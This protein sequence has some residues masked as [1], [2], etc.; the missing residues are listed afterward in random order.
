MDEQQTQFS[1]KT[2][3]RRVLVDYFS[4]HVVFIRKVESITAS[5]LVD[6]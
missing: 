4:I 3:A 5:K 2:E 6:D 1:G